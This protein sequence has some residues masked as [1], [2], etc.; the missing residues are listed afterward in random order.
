[1]GLMKVVIFVHLAQGAWVFSNPYYF[2][3]KDFYNYDGSTYTL[4][5]YYQLENRVLF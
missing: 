2:P 3:K 5:G 1:M 4:D